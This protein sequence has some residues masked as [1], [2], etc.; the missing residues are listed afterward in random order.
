[1]PLLIY[2]IPYRTGVNLGN[3]TLL[4]LAESANIGG[5]KAPMR[6]RAPTCCVYAGQNSA[7]WPARMRCSGRM[8]AHDPVAASLVPRHCDSPQIR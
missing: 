5:V 1:M 6:H 2:N 8:N 7:Y 4:R 3:D